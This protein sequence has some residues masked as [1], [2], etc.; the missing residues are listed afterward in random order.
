[1]DVLNKV[2]KY[3]FNYKESCNQYIDSII[4]DMLES[5]LSEKDLKN[6]NEYRKEITIVYKLI[7]L[8]DNFEKNMK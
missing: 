6:I 1:M 7:D 3:L 2:R 4:Y 5:D 8:I